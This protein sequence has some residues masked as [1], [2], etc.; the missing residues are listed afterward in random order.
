M[1][2]IKL[3]PIGKKHQRSFRIVVAEKKSKLNGR[4]IEDLGWLNPHSDTFHVENE[5]AREWISKGAQPT[6]SVHNVLIRSGAIEGKKIAV[7]S[8][9]RK[10]GEAE[11]KSAETHAPAPTPEVPKAEVPAEGEIKKEGITESTEEKTE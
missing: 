11:V 10:K 2:A 8:T 1:L 7:H 6:D 3:K 9:K 4:F 5:K